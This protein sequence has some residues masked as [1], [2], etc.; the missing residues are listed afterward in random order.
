MKARMES[1][2]KK[3][4]AVT[5]EGKRYLEAEMNMGKVSL[6]SIVYHTNR[7]EGVVVFIDEHK[8]RHVQFKNGD[9]HKYLPTR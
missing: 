1:E 7:G 3:H 5:E 8:R 2:M 9:I 4:M 6:G